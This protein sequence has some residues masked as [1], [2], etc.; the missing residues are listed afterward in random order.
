MFTFFQKFPASDAKDYF[1]GR[2]YI[3][4]AQVHRLVAGRVT[5]QRFV[6]APLLR[7]AKVEDGFAHVQIGKAG[8]AIAQTA[9]L[10]ESVFAVHAS[11]KVQ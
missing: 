1:D 10:P 4:S 7:V 6:V 3:E 2:R 8:D 5:E 9:S 11:D